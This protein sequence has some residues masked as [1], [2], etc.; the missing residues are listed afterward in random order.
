MEAAEPRLLVLVREGLDHGQ[1][2]LAPERDDGRALRPVGHARHMF[3]TR[4]RPRVG[5][6]RSTDITAGPGG[7]MTDEVGVVTGDL[8]I[9]TEV[10]D[11]LAVTVRVQYKDADEW[12]VVTNG[13]TTV[14]D[15]ADLDAVH[16]VAVG[17]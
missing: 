3:L 12:Y 8:T 7:V 10:D 1:G 17:L 14:R 11:A 13:R 2:V 5:D 16:A 4:K 15:A 6:A 9:R